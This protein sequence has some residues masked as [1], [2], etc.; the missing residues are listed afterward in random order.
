MS[1]LKSGPSKPELCHWTFSVPSR[2]F[3]KSIYGTTSEYS[4]LP[5]ICTHNS[6]SWHFI[7]RNSWRCKNELTNPSLL[8]NISCITTT[9][10]VFNINVPIRCIFVF[11]LT[12]SWLVL[13]IWFVLWMLTTQYNL[14]TW[15][16]RCHQTRCNPV[17]EILNCDKVHLTIKEIW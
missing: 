10:G 13:W 8:Y 16:L 9:T 6:L 17:S 14:S 3:A 12:V 11:V 15:I 5:T 7:L 1:L 4:I 2:E